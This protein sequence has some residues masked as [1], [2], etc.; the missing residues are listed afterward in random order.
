MHMQ[1]A[2]TM[3]ELRE[4]TT[5]VIRRAE[6]DGGVAIRRQGRTVAFVVS[7]ERMDSLI[8]TVEILAD[9]KLMKSILDYESGAMQAN[10]F[11]PDDA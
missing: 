11:D 7:R 10:P 4:Q 1:S 9:Q 5:Q 8:E 3:A 6:K 2:V